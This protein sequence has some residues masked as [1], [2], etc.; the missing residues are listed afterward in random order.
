MSPPR[1]LLRYKDLGQSA[2]FDTMHN[3]LVNES[4][5]LEAQLIYVR[6]AA[7][8]VQNSQVIITDYPTFQAWVGA[9]QRRAA[10]LKLELLQHDA[11]HGE[12]RQRPSAGM[13]A[14]VQR[15]ARLWVPFSKKLALRSIE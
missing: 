11:V 4:D 13:I 2:A 9:T 14:A 7:R 3:I 12:G 10:E 6:Q 15:K 8:C 1:Q 5:S